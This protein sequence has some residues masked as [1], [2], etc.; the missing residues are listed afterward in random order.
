MNTRNAPALHQSILNAILLTVIGTGVCSQASASPQ[1]MLDQPRK[2]AD[3]L[4]N[5]LDS[6]L[7]RV[8]I[9]MPDLNDR[10]LFNELITLAKSK[11][12]VRLIL[13]TA[14]PGIKTWR[15]IPCTD[16]EAEGVD[17]RFIDSS[18]RS[19]FAIIDGPRTRF[20]SGRFGKVLS[21]KGRIAAGEGNQLIRITK[22]GDYILSFQDE[23]NHL[24]SKA[25]DYGDRAASKKTSNVRVPAVPG[26][27]FTSANMIPV[28]TP[29]GWLLTPSLDQQH[30]VLENFVH[31]AV[32]YAY[33]SIDLSVSAVR[34]PQLYQALINAKFRGVKIRV[35]VDR[36]EFGGL[37]A[38][39]QCSP[40]AL[41]K[42]IQIAD[43]C[44]TANS[45]QVIYR[46]G[47]VS[48]EDTMA[49]FL[50]IDKKLVLSGPVGAERNHEFSTIDHLLVLPEHTH[51]IY[52][53]NFARQISNSI[54]VT[55]QLM[56][57]GRE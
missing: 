50:L 5:D 20:S 57:S 6:A 32:D 48:S 3:V 14:E 30:G 42:N 46:S 37:V 4:L 18:L 19:R 29:N 11:K 10:V 2:M 43:E 40:A 12:S 27:Y 31:G 52:A 49:G 55:N 28:K 44:L 24:W 16:L 21:F 1:V 45:V 8:D 35:I 17:I 34:N 23:F 7:K 56:N 39:E 15:C 53:H 22:S 47:P 25:S 51:A 33:T 9:I 26:V 38:K 36:R 54:P 13:T 41:A